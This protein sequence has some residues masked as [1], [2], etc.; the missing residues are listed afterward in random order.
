MVISILNRGSTLF[1][2]LV[3]KFS[4]LRIVRRAEM[5]DRTTTYSNRFHLYF[6]K[7][8]AIKTD[9]IFFCLQAIVYIIEKKNFS[10]FQIYIILKKNFSKKTL[11]NRDF[12]TGGD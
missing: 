10:I 2:A 9:N 1:H 4:V 12:Q 8:R 5:K 3:H 11:K 6:T 7:R